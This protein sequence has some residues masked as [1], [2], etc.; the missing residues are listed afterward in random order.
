MTIF[1]RHAGECPVTKCAHNHGARGLACG[2]GMDA[3]LVCL[4][5]RHKAR[6]RELVVL[7][8]E[9]GTLDLEAAARGLTARAAMASR[10]ATEMLPAEAASRACQLALE[11]GA[12]A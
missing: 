10:T 3:V 11:L 12:E 1:T 5:P 6:F 9:A 7:D 2:F 4:H 8:R